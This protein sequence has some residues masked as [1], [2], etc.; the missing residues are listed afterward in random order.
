MV[1]SFLVTTAI[2]ETWPKNK[3]ILFLGVF[4]HDHGV[5]TRGAPTCEFASDVHVRQTKDRYVGR[6]DCACH[7]ARVCVAVFLCVRAVVLRRRTDDV[8]DHYF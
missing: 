8:F 2:E 3:S 6:D 7:S 4:C 1:K 5:D